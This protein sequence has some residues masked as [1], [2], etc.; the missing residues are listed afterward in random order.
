MGS[1]LLDNIANNI[2]KLRS[3]SFCT[4]CAHYFVLV[5]KTQ[6]RRSSKESASPKSLILLVGTRFTRRW[7]GGGFECAEGAQALQRRVNFLLKGIAFYSPMES[8]RLC[9]LRLPA[10][11]AV[12]PLRINQP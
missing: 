2:N 6:K 12:L 7:W 5:D 8:I 1:C 10:P 9:G 4:L 3:Y 11:K